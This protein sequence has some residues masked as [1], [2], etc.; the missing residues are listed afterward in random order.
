MNWHAGNVIA[1]E[2]RRRI[3]SR[4]ARVA[5]WLQPAIGRVRHVPH[6][7]VVLGSLALVMLAAALVVYTRS[8]ADDAAPTDHFMNFRCPACGKT[9]TLNDRQ[10]EQLW[11]KHEFQRAADGQSLCY[12]CPNCGKLA[13]VR[14]E[15]RRPASPVDANTPG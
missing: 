12:K 1:S 15:P 6:R 11:R 13:A 14:S 7:T 10:F 2:L 3:G 9:F 5:P 8:G 4:I